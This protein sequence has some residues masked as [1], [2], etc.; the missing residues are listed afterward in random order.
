MVAAPNSSHPGT[1]VEKGSRASEDGRL[2]A[3]LYNERGPVF[4]DDAALKEAERKLSA[5]VAERTLVLIDDV[6]QSFDDAA[7]QKQPEGLAA[8]ASL[9]KAKEMYVS[10]FWLLLW[11]GAGVAISFVWIQD[12]NR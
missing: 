5:D 9:G 12:L 2:K 4:E 1:E 3:P 7:E 11:C 10:M 8:A 6:L